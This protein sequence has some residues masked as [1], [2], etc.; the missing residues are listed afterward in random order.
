[1][2]DRA[3]V[4]HS[5]GEQNPPGSAFCWSCRSYLEW[6]DQ[7]KASPRDGTPE[8][9]GA[10]QRG[11]SSGS[12]PD[13]AG[14]HGMGEPPPDDP[15][16]PQD[17]PPRE[18]RAPFEAGVPEADLTLAVD[19]TPLTVTVNVANTSSVVDGY[20][21]EAVDAPH[22]LL[23]SPAR[24]ELLPGTQGVIEAELRI[25]SAGL[26]PAQQLPLL[27]RV[28]NTSGRASHH[29]V[30]VRVTV[31]V[32][33][34]PVE[35]RT[36]PRMVRTRDLEPAVCTV[37]VDNSRSN[38]WAQVR[39]SAVDA[40]HVVRVTWVSSHLQVPPSGE[41]RTEVRFEAPPPEPGGEVSRAITVDAS[42]GQR[43]AVTTV[44]LVQ[45]ASLPAVELLT[46]DLDPSVLRLDGRRRGQLT[47]VVDNR[48]GSE[49]AS[50]SLRGDD[51]EN[52]LGFTFSPATLRV[53][54]GRLAS[55]K[56]S[57]T[58][59]RTPPGKEVTRAMEIVASDG[60][61]DTRADGSVVQLASSR[62]GL[63]RVLLTVL[64]GLL[65][66][67]G[68]LMP[69]LAR[70]ALTATDLDEP[71]IIGRIDQEFPVTPQG[72]DLAG[73]ESLLSVGLLLMVVAAFMAFGLTGRSGRLTRWAA[74]LG[75]IIVVGALVGLAVLRFDVSP[76]WGAPVA[77]LGCVCGYIGGL[78][79]RR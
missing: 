63:A 13:G 69:F 48:R 73:Y 2:N 14:A 34:A 50:V 47:A 25:A 9:A 42:D 22:W 72:L 79:A 51:P 61:V 12:P 36:E 30:P 21:L 41:A 59:P 18:T 74:L 46:L 49:T 66:V 20:V 8:Q 1:M 29:D 53:E 19:G 40:E 28:H 76:G 24:L 11:S 68:A 23:A 38:H 7:N 3:T 77:F 62:R 78:L 26:V 37:I 58:A 17:A 16:E 10:P 33:E 15:R 27:L 54:P 44:T 52:S 75:A 5:C 60:H 71:L 64:G 56:V 45:T 39:L 43:T 35:V 32:L 6:Q 55:S 57:V 4:C 67:A 31:P 65:V 70:E